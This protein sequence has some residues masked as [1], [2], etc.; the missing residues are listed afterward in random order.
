M[1]LKAVLGEVAHR[2][3]I[4]QPLRPGAVRHERI[5]LGRLLH[6]QDRS[7]QK[8]QRLKPMDSLTNMDAAEK[9]IYLEKIDYNERF[10]NRV[11]CCFGETCC[12]EETERA[13]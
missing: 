2:S 13:I 11:I 1:E 9:I 3:I 4:F 5:E 8:R 12:E 7:T 6:E 10:E